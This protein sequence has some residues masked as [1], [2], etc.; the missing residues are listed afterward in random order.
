MQPLTDYPGY[1]V[2]EEGHVWSSFSNKFL[3]E[4]LQ[5]GGRLRVWIAGRYRNLSRLVAQTYHPNPDNLPEVN[6]KDE[7]PTN[8][9]KDNLEWVS[10]TY[11]QSYS[12]SRLHMFKSPDGSLVMVYNLREFCRNNNL[13]WG[14]VHRLYY[15]KQKQTKGWSLWFNPF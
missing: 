7:I 15:G 4:V 13:N 2:N 3:A 1:F 10:K 12:K 8:N 5:N 14:S 6:H 9:H 11:N